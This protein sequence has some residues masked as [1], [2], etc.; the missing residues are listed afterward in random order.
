MAPLWALLWALPLASLA[1]R[2][3][4]V[5]SLLERRNALGSEEPPEI[6]DD[7]PLPE[8]WEKKIRVLEP[9]GQ[10]GFGR[11]FKAQVICEESAASASALVAMKVMHNQRSS[12]EEVEALRDM[13][14]ASWYCAGAV[15]RPGHVKFEGQHY[16]LMPFM[17]KGDL[18]EVLKNCYHSHACRCNRQPGEELC[19]EALGRPF[20][21]DMVLALFLQVMKGVRA[22]HEHHIVH[23]DLKPENVMLHCT[24]G[25]CY[26]RVV[27]LGL[28]CRSGRNC[29][30][31]GTV[32]YIAPEVWKGVRV[33]VPAND[34]FSLGVILYMLV[35]G[36]P[37]PFHGDRDGESTTH[38]KPH[39]DRY[40]RPWFQRP[41]GHLMA[42]MLNLRP[43]RRIPLERA[44]DELKGILLNR[45]L[46]Q[47]ILQMMEHNPEETGAMHPLPQCLEKDAGAR[48]S[49]TGLLGLL[50]LSAL[51]FQ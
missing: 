27:D 51:I 20:S 29:H 11:V 18:H 41:L 24:D 25:H 9:L 42:K 49:L 7:P 35:V 46:S 50:A 39:L 37:P 12:H 15:G 14:G 5:Q 13:R 30:S 44:I 17:N 28:S 1:A 22:M 36:H 47:E 10:G 23:M 40:I 34:V 26:A 38:Y 6:E 45:N 4:V 48:K 43:L 31:L 21:L 19:W 2:V 32:G 3:A 16:A 8:Q 33:G